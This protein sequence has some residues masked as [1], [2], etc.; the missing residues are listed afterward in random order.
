MTAELLWN[1]SSH[2]FTKRYEQITDE[3]KMGV[4]TSICEDQIQ[5]WTG[6]LLS[7]AL[8]TATPSEL[9]KTE[10]CTYGLCVGMDLQSQGMELNS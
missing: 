5:K 1:R 6:M 9:H 10:Q 4:D 7:R 2:A 8:D 3:Q